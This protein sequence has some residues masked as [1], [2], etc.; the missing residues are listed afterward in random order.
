MFPGQWCVRETTAASWMAKTREALRLR[1]MDEI[2]AGVHTENAAASLGMARGT[3][4]VCCSAASS[5]TRC[6]WPTRYA[7]ASRARVAQRSVRATATRIVPVVS[8]TPCRDHLIKG[9]KHGSPYKSGAA[10]GAPNP[11]GPGSNPND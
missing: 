9:S 10:H 2:E 6:G 8:V 7:A 1:A 3:V 5:P 4:Y 11:T